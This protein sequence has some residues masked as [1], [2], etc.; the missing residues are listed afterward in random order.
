MYILSL[1][2]IFYAL[3]V[4]GH[5]KSVDMRYFFRC[6]SV[7]VIVSCVANSIM[8]TD[9]LNVSCVNT[10]IIQ[11]PFSNL[12]F[13]NTDYNRLASGYTYMTKSETRVLFVPILIDEY[14][15]Q[16]ELEWIENEECF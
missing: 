1:I 6:L 3:E 8:W 10:L 5:F 12:F 16:N 13:K 7:F 2:E 14:G 9:K 15:L 4:F 11:I